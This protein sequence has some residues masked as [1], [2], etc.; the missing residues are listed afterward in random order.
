MLWTLH[1]LPLPLLA[2]LGR[3]VGSAIGLFA[4]QRRHIVQRNLALCFP[5]LTAEARAK[6]V[7]EHFAYLGRSLLERGV[8]WWAARERLENLLQIEGLEVVESLLAQ[9][10]PVILLAPHF[11][12]LDAGGT[13][14]T[15]HFNTVNLYAEQSNPV[16]NDMVLNGRRRF[17]DQKL[18][19][20]Q[21]GILATVKAMRAGRPFHYSPD[22][23][24]R[25]RDATF[26]PFFGIAAATTSGLPRL[27]KAAKAVVVPCVTTFLPDQKGY[28]VRLS[29]PWQNYP[30]G[31][32][33]E[34][35]ARMNHWLESEIRQQPA[36]YYWVHRRFKTRPPGEPKLY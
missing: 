32:L 35:L 25:R 4:R 11:L 5:E 10:T 9:Q 22:T 29:P 33:E 16:L 17:G 31:H 13:A 8:L 18:L 7:R 20:R 3:G 6:L 28:R 34:D 2:A 1:F 19:S 27:A 14:I 23:N 15:L 30:S 24:A 21:E 36:Q 26:V 12:G